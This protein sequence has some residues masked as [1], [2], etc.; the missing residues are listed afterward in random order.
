MRIRLSRGGAPLCGGVQACAHVRVHTPPPTNLTAGGGGSDTVRVGVVDEYGVGMPGKTVCAV[1][2]GG[3]DLISSA[4]E[5]IEGEAG[6]C[7]V[8]DAAGNATLGPLSFGYDSS[9]PTGAER[10]L[11]FQANNSFAADDV[12]CLTAQN[13]YIPT[14]RFAISA[15]SVAS[16]LCVVCSVYCEVFGV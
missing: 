6:N 2:G 5:G 3:A 9:L 16:S 11:W 14:C 13:A 1:S 4:G 12:V 15:Q 8:T 10:L 7:G